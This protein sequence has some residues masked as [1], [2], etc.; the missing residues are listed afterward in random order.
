MNVSGSRDAL[1]SSFCKFWL[2]E[3]SEFSHKIYKKPLR[4]KAGQ[5]VD[6]AG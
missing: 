2:D 6:L 3:R 4:S 1:A 5:S